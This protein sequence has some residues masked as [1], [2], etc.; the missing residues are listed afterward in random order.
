MVSEDLQKT[1]DKI[2]TKKKDVEDAKKAEILA[3][4]ALDEAVCL[5]SSLKKEVEDCERSVLHKENLYRRTK[6]DAKSVS[7]EVI[8]RRET[9]R[10][11]LLRKEEC[12]NESGD[13]NDTDEAESGT[14]EDSTK[15]EDIIYSNRMEQIERYLKE[16]NDLI[17]KISRLGEE[18][19]QLR[20]KSRALIVGGE[21]A[22]R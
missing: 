19:S 20:E 13:E 5:V 21:T 22:G 2:H 12:M 7:K 3:W 11:S 18:A 4:A 14:N 16:E 17:G 1:K 9:V 15:D 10:E 8:K 6:V